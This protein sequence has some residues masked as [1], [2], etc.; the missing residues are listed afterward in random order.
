[1][2]VIFENTPSR[3]NLPRFSIGLIAWSGSLGLNPLKIATKECDFKKH[4]RLRPKSREQNCATKTGLWRGSLDD[5]EVIAKRFNYY[6]GIA[7]LKPL[8]D[9]NRWVGIENNSDAI[10]ISQVFWLQ[11]RDCD[12]LWSLRSMKL[13]KCCLTIRKAALNFQAEHGIF[14]SRFWE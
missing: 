11:P 6:I 1:M 9:S 2:I 12:L 4:P 8:F 7:N 14:L 10:E 5:V 13:L 3:A